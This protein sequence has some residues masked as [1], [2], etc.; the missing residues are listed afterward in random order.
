MDG[1]F[2]AMLPRSHPEWARMW[3]RLFDVAGSYEDFSPESFQRW[4][5]IGTFWGNFQVVGP[6]GSVIILAHQF[7]HRDRPM[8]ARPI[9]ALGR[10]YGRVYVSLAASWQLSGGRSRWL[11]EGALVHCASRP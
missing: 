6:P 2:F 11:P 10:S 4:Q 1:T 7:R 9:A 8:A 3:K 5:Y